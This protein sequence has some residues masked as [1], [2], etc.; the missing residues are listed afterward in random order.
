MEESEN[1]VA[2]SINNAFTFMED[3]FANGQE[4]VVF[5]T[6]LTISPDAALFLAEH[7]IE[8][9]NIYKEQLLIGTRKAQILE[10]LKS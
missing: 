8:K 4:L 1:L 3:A 7:D 9:Y 2:S 6:E 10:E 5:V